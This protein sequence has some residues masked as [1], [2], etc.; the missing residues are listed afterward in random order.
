MRTLTTTLGAAALLMIQSCGTPQEEKPTDATPVAMPE[1]AAPAPPPF[2]PFDV[3]EIQH[4][5]KDYA[6]WKKAFDADS[7]A[8]NTNGLGF[9]VIGRKAENANDLAIYLKASDV[10]KAKS[11]A[12]DPRLKD[13]MQKNGVVSKPSINYWHMIRFNPEAKEK[14]WVT[15][16]HR[17]K[18][19][20]AWL[21]VFDT[22][23]TEARATEGLYDVALARGIDDPNI[24]HIVFDV[25]D[26]AQAQAS[27]GSDTKKA[28]M[29]SAGV[30]GPP[31]ITFYTTA[32]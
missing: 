18:D 24:V 3:V 2:E 4:G 20:D 13:V 21:K 11:F 31:T 14:T 23:G 1:P 17:V 6:P 26:V 12:N 22:E 28:L 32:E 27:I 8:R 10:A 9:M 15:I 29:M 30:K 16:T 7:T 25:K 5:V 19:F